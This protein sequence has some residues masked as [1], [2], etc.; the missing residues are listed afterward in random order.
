MQRLLRHSLFKLTESAGSALFFRML[1]LNVLTFFK[2]CIIIFAILAIFLSSPTVEVPV[3]T[4]A[5]KLAACAFLLLPLPTL[6]G[7]PC[8]I[9]MCMSNPTSSLPGQCKSE[10]NDYFKIREYKKGDFSASRTAN[11]RK[12]KVNDKCPDAPAHEK[13][14][15]HALFGRMYSNPFSFY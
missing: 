9:I 6:A 8:A 3:K 2:K 5:V 14:R 10:T 4:T 11:K 12:Q 13:E 1:M 7:S 15:I